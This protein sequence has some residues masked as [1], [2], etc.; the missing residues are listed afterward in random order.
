MRYFAMV[1][2]GF[3]VARPLALLRSPHDGVLESFRADR[4]WHADPRVELLTGEA[5]RDL[6]ELTTAQAERLKLL[7]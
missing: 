6:V 7:W 2:A 3:P 1:A 4:R 5:E